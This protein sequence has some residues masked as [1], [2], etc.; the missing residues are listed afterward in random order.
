MEP[1]S[2]TGRI[3]I[4]SPEKQNLIK[5]KTEEDPCLA[6]VLELYSNGWD[7]ELIEFSNSTVIGK[8]IKKKDFITVSDELIFFNNCIVVPKALRKELMVKLHSDHIGYEKTISKT[9][10]VVYWP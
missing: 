7:T 8:C 2:S 10:P 6:R 4:V 5:L 3:L 1:S 9:K